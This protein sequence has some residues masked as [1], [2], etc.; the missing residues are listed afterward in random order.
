METRKMLHVLKYLYFSLD[1]AL[2]VRSISGINQV[3][4]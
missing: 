2:G 3:F 4:V 1:M